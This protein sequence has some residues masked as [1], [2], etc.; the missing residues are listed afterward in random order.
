MF[1]TPRSSPACCARRRARQ[2]SPALGA[3]KTSVNAFVA[4]E[5]A[6]TKCSRGAR[7]CS[8]RLRGRTLNR[9]RPKPRAER[10]AGLSNAPPRERTNSLIAS[11]FQ[12]FF[13][14]HP[15]RAI[16]KAR[17]FQDAGQQIS[18]APGQKSRRGNREELRWRVQAE[19]EEDRGG[20]GDPHH[21]DAD[22]QARP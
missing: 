6:T 15:R 14:R 3:G 22:D 21:D 11:P 9:P 8:G 7:S 18:Q 16:L 13:D 17:A 5:A 4:A 10:A 2:S 20:D 1:H 12:I 19:E